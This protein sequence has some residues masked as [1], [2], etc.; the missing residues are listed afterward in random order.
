MHADVCPC[1]SVCVCLRPSQWIVSSSLFV[2]EC[3]MQSDNHKLLL[4]IIFNHSYFIHGKVIFHRI[5]A[6]YYVLKPGHQ[7]ITIP[8]KMAAE[9]EEDEEEQGC[10]R[11]NG[12]TLFK[13]CASAFMKWQ[14]I[15][16][17]H[18][19]VLLLLPMVNLFFISRHVEL[20]KSQSAHPANIKTNGVWQASH[21]HA[22]FHPIY[23]FLFN[24]H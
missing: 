6:A 13:M 1:A 20:A 7:F 2:V 21:I 15:R 9:R 18:S 3:Q 22:L 16:G 10:A 11:S 14:F 4:S 5:M 23:R 8:T 24:T 19:F 17:T 12:K